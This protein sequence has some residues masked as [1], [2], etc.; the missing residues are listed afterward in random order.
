MLIKLRRFDNGNVFL[1]EHSQIESVAFV[2]DDEGENGIAIMVGGRYF[3]VREDLQ[4]LLKELRLATTPGW[5]RKL[6][7]WLGK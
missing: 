1:I 2:T 5:L 6:Y 3:K 7:R 4:Y